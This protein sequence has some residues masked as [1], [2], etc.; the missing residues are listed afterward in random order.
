MKKEKPQT[1][2]QKEKEVKKKREQVKLPAMIKQILEDDRKL[3]RKYMDT[4][5]GSKNPDRERRDW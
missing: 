5:T 4:S 2:E 1:V 3:Q